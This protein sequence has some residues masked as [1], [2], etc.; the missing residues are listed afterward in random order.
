MS[1][2]NK[3]ERVAC[4][5][6]VSTQE[7]KLHGLSLDAQRDTLNHYAKTHHLKMKHNFDFASFFNYKIFL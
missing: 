5:I 7:Q 3:A 1:E 2:N 6:R 4:Y